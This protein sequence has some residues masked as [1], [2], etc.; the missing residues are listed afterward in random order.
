M[1]Q[2][3]LNHIMH[4]NGLQDPN[5]RYFQRP[6]QQCSG[7]FIAAAR[8]PYGH[9]RIMLADVTGH[10]LQAALFLL[11]IF[12]IFYTMVRKGLSTQNIVTEINDIM[13][14]I[15]ITGRFIAAVVVRITQDGTSLEVWNG[16]VA[17]AFYVQND[18][19][20]HK[21]H[22]QHPPLGL[23]EAEG[24]DT[25]T[26]TIYPPPGSLVLCSDG[27]T[28]AENTYGEP[29]GEERLETVLRTSS[30]D[31]L[32]DDLLL[33]ADT[34]LAGDLPHDDLSIVVAHVPRGTSV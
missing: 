17:V 26:E 25:S 28:E 34:H 30:Q 7:D 2:E 3:V 27:L 24:F 29:F 14:E 31:T 9:L 33:V 6:A 19:A 10:G 11:P 18:G 32:L 22:S 12:R 1:A 15:S 23:V 5:I 20:I 21:F 16:G 13:R 8:D 4:S